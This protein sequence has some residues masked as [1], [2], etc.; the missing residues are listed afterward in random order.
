MA[1]PASPGARFAIWFGSTLLVLP[2]QL[3]FAGAAV[4][5]IGGI[6]LGGFEPSKLVWLPLGLAAV[7]MCAAM[8][9][10]LSI[11]SRVH[12]W[13]FRMR[14]SEV[15]RAQHGEGPVR[16]R[17]AE[18][19]LRFTRYSIEVAARGPV[20]ELRPARAREFAPVSKWWAHPL[21]LPHPENPRILDRL[22]IVGFVLLG[23]WVLIMLIA[24]LARA[25]LGA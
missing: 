20:R 2:F 14:L 24:W 5:S 23:F 21:A 6:F 18:V 11:V 22:W 7:A 17:S 3:V 4:F 15:A 9:V 13:Q 12:W 16:L 25:V 10:Q 8:T 19:R 1:Y